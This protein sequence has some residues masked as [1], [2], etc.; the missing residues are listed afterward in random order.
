ME[1]SVRTNFKSARTWSQFNKLRPSQQQWRSINTLGK[2]GAKALK[3]LKNAG[4]V[5]TV[6]ITA[7]STVNT[8]N[9]Y[10]NGV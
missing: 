7:Y 9:Y 4:N 2:D 10:N 5:A 8:F 1:Y 3:F 6:I